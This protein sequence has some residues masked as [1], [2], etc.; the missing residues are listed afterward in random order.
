M[1]KLK[2]RAAALSVA[3]RILHP[4]HLMK[5]V[6][7]QRQRKQNQRSYDDVQLALLAQLLPSGFL[8]Y[9]YF[10]DPDRRPET[11]SLADIAAAQHRYAELLLEH[12][13]D[14]AAPVLDVGCGMGGLTK[15][16]LERA[17][18]PV[19][20]TPDRIQAEHVRQT[21][22]NVPVIRSKFENLPDPESH[23]GRYGTVFTSESLQYLNLSRALPLLAK[24]LKPGGT[25]VAC[26]YFHRTGT[27]TETA[28]NSGHDWD[29]FHRQLESHGWTVTLERDITAHVL[30][31]LR[32]IRMWGAG[33]GVPVLAFAM[34][35]LRSKQP[36]VHYFLTDVLKM[37]DDVIEDNLRLVDPEVF[38]A[39]KRYALLVI[40]RAKSK[41]N[42][43]HAIPFVMLLA[44]TATDILQ[45]LALAL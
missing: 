38:A 35:K 24:L 6:K 30:P 34:L 8:H 25:W 17:F 12:A 42:G 2:A 4:G 23:Y 1:R 27:P 13:Q 36:A 15:L 28:G 39:H 3:G 5:A 43:S 14:R 7:L 22:P 37:L 11:I 31:T 41:A 9:G 44:M 21:Y 32:V 26:D 16:L 20:L 18:S 33:I 45:R 19:A 40:R 10:D 29:D